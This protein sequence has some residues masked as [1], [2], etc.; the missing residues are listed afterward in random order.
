MKENLTK[1]SS[2]LTTICALPTKPFYAILKPESVTIPGDE[3]SRTNPGHGYGE[4]SVDYWSMETF[5]TK[6]EW[7]AEIERLSLLT[8]YGSSGNFKAVKISPVTIHKSIKV[9][10]EGGDE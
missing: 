6:E 10:I 2:F 3:R 1:N 5:A 9:A 7:L 4:H 8:G